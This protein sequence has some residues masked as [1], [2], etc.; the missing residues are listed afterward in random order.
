MAYTVYALEKTDHALNI[1]NLRLVI[2]YH[3]LLNVN[4]NL[5]TKYEN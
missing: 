5:R 3:F 1:Q 4:E 2:H